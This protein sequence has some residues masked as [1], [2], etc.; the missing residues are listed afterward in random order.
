[1]KAKLWMDKNLKY[2]TLVI[3]VAAT[4]I[5][6]WKWGDLIWG[7]RLAFFL[8]DAL[9]IHELEEMLTGFAEE[10]MDVVEGDKQVGLGQLF[11]FLLGI[12]LPLISIL[13]PAQPWLLEG[14]LI[15]G[16]LELP[17]HI[18]TLRRESRKKKYY[19]GMVSAFTIVPGVAVWILVYLIMNGL[20]IHWYW[21]IFG[22][23]HVLFLFVLC[24]FLSVR[25]MGVKY[26]D[27]WK[28]VRGNF[29]KNSGDN[30]END[31]ACSD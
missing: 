16:I 22:I 4:V 15:L 2:V 8:Y 3:A 19:P 11:L 13:F 12:Y 1:M 31:E 17:A 28:G 29:R 25:T 5:L 9:A 21:W 23:I 14:Y 30:G 26:K 10:T 24:Q 20:M 27:F 18:S 7:Q 6:I